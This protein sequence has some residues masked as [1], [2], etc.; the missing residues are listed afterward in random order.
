MKLFTDASYSHRDGIGV[1]GFVLLD[2]HTLTE[3][4][5]VGKGDH[6]RLELEAIVR[7]L[8]QVKVGSKVKVFT[9]STYAHQLIQEGTRMEA[10]L[11]LVSKLFSLTS[12]R[13]VTFRLIERRQKSLA[14]R[15]DDLVRHTLRRKNEETSD[16]PKV[17]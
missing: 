6:N 5:G 7:G 14:K 9:D 8:E 17:H 4:V 1:W 16:S 13:R 12:E 10:N 3:Q 11:D 2:D 15:V